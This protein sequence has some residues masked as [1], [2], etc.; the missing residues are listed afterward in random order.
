MRGV[1]HPWVVAPAGIRQGVSHQQRLSLEDPLGAQAQQL[2]LLARWWLSGPAAGLHHAQ[3]RFGGVEQT[4]VEQTDEAV[5][6]TTET[7]QQGSDVMGAA[8][9][10]SLQQR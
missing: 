6:G 10:I 3:A 1:L 2:L 9:Q 4:V 8:A 5:G 7:P